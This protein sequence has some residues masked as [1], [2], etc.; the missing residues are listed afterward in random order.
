MLISAEWI[1]ARLGKLIFQIPVTK[2]SGQENALG[3][4]EDDHAFS[5]GINHFEKAVSHCPCSMATLSE[6]MRRFTG[7]C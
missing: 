6:L 3:L 5:L 2:Q 7:R 1:D 4:C